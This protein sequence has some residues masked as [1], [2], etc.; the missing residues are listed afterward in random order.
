[1]YY[2]ASPCWCNDKAKL[3]SSYSRYAKLEIDAIEPIYM[4]Y[5]GIDSDLNRSV[6]LIMAVVLFW[7]R[8]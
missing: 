5:K 1:M 6:E 4:E 8:G 7:V 2:F 3:R